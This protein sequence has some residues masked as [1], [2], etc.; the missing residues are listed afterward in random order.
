MSL[1]NAETA[2]QGRTA[3]LVERCRSLT[4]D[5]L[6]ADARERARTLCLDTVGVLLGSAGSTESSAIVRDMAAAIYGDGPATVAGNEQGVAPPVAA[7]ANGTIAHGLELDDTH[8]AG[9]VHPGAVVV[10]TVLAVGETEGASG[11]ELLEAV[12]AGYEL[13]CRVGR[14]AV[15]DRLYERGFHPTSCCGVFG[16]AL[17]AAKLQGCSAEET[18]NAVGIAG[19]FAAGNLEYLAQGTLSKRI[20][21]GVAAQ[22]GVTAAALAARG[23]TGPATI[24]DGENGFLRAYA[25]GGDPSML[26]ADID[27]GHA[28]EIT[29]TGIKPHACCRYNQAPIDAALALQREHGFDA[30]EIASVTAG[31]AETALPIVAEPHA[32]KSDPTSPTDA[33]FSLQY[34]VAVALQEGRAFLE[35]FQEPFLTDRSVLDLADR[36]TAEAAP[37][38]TDA[39]PDGFPTRVT[40]ETTGGERYETTLRTCRGDPANPLS[41]AE[42]REKYDTLAARELDDGEADALAERLLDLESVEDVAEITGFLRG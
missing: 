32:E 10:P 40:V 29:R 30:D 8:S 12:V 36:V 41:Q 2:T 3:E 39:Y 17:S 38:L 28:F 25:D 33:Q 6:T 20:Q 5:D 18:R 22:A 37:D 42:I 19:S 27:D 4:V 26:L 21:P 11:T 13:M 15:P 16:A 23:Y 35:Q 34:S 24:L 31:I 1:E 7:F 14:A 9:S